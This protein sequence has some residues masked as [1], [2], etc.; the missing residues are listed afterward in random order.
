MKVAVTLLA[1]IG[2]FGPVQPAPRAATQNCGSAR[3][4]GY[5]GDLAFASDQGV[6]VLVGSV[7]PLT[8]K[9]VRTSIKQLETNGRVVCDLL[10][11]REAKRA[12]DP[13][14]TVI[15]VLG[16]LDVD[17]QFI[18]IFGGG[19]LTVR[20][21]VST[22]SLRR[23]RSLGN[24]SFPID[25]LGLGNLDM[26]P[27]PVRLGAEFLTLSRTRVVQFEQFHPQVGRI[28]LETDSPGLLEACPGGWRGKQ[29]TDQSSSWGTHWKQNACVPFRRGK[30]ANLPDAWSSDFHLSVF[31]RAKGQPMRN[32]SVTLSYNAVDPSSQC[33]VDE[34]EISCT[35]YPTR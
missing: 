2:G 24:A 21:W 23:I 1:M 4:V 14:S 6:A 3:F 25:S 8:A 22:E 31:V 12:L 16:K 33:F 19:G 30:P 29:P 27:S 9:H 28:R 13:P 20:G 7:D 5:D 17:D 34:R 32:V 18:A 10:K 15:D 35:P 11:V 26:L